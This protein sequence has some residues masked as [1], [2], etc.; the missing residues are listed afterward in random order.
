MQR[1]PS[2]FPRAFKS[3]AYHLILCILIAQNSY[4]ESPIRIPFMRYRLAHLITAFSDSAD[5]RSTNRLSDVWRH[6]L[7]GG[8]P[9]IADTESDHTLLLLDRITTMSVEQLKVHA[10]S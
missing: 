8:G 9:I 6:R 7:R 4:P 5:G 10:S 3:V 2:A 1:P